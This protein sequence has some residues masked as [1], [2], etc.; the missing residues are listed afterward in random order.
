MG[1]AE[2]IVKHG[3]TSRHP[4]SRRGPMQDLVLPIAILVR[5]RL[6][7]QVPHEIC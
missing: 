4:S 3:G 5:A 7:R 2:E 6:R 1:K